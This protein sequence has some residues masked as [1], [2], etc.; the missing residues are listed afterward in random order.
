[1]VKVEGRLE[2]ALA[3]A[4]GEYSF[5]F[6]TIPAQDDAQRFVF[7]NKG[8]MGGFQLEV[9]NRQIVELGEK[10]PDWLVAKTAA[11]ASRAIEKPDHYWVFC[12]FAK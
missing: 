5:S 9:T 7:H 6:Q 1:M 3:Q 8:G 11:A 4:A 12:F 10:F 2:K